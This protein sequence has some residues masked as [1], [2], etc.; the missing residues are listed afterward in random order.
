MKDNFEEN[1]VP[2]QAFSRKLYKLQ[3]LSAKFLI[4]CLNVLL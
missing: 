3:T 2:K 4:D 1:Y